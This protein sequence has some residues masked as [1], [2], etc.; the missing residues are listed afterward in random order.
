LEGDEMQ[1]ALEWMRNGLAIVGLVALGYWMGTGRQVRAA[2]S[3]GDG[4]EFQMDGVSDN[5]AL[6]VYHPESK[7]LYVY[8]GATVGSSVVQC[9]FK[10]QIGDPGAAL[11]RT[12]CPIGSA[13]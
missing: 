12:N 13:Q 5:S 8:R 6:M 2:S 4:V 11:R 3:S 9:A 10:F 1:R 7:S